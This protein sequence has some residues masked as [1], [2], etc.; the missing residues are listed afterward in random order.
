MGIDHRVGSIEKGKDA[1]L[2]IFNA[3]PLSI[4]AIPQLTIVDGIVYFDRNNDKADMRLEIE[5]EEK[6]DFK[7]YERWKEKDKCMQDV[8]E[9]LFFGQQYHHSLH[10]H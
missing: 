3:H 8:T 10:G 7:F 6:F 5:P 4:Y 9:T 1:D 2:V